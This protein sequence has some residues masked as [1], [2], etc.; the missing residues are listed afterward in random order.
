MGEFAT[1]I[2]DI[3]VCTPTSRLIELVG[4]VKGFGVLVCKFE[5]VSS[6]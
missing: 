2:E 5:P 1:S 6:F 4:E 3:D